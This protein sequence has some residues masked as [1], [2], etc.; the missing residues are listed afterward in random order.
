MEL[1]LIIAFSTFVAILLLQVLV[2]LHQTSLDNVDDYVGLSYIDQHVVLQ[3]NWVFLAHENAIANSQIFDQIKASLNVI[4][5][6]EVSTSVLLGS[7]LVFVWNHKVIYDAFLQ[8]IK[9]KEV[10]FESF[11]FW[12]IYLQ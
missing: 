10:I 5:D 2:L 11:L 9:L 12:H 4:A 3:H 7:L 1:L 8:Q 6:L